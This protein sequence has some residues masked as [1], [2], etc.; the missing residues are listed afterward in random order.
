MICIHKDFALNIL[1]GFFWLI[2]IFDFLE[3]FQMPQYLLLIILILI[4]SYVIIFRTQLFVNLIIYLIIL[5]PIFGAFKLFETNILLSDI[6]LLFSTLILLLRKKYVKNHYFF[7]LIYFLLFLHVLIHLALEDLINIKPLV[8]IIE[9]FA[10]YFA[11][12]ETLKGEKNSSIFFSVIVATALGIILMIFAFFKGISLVNFEG[13]SQALIRDSNGIDLSKFRMTFFYTNFPFIISSLV[14]ILI[15]FL[16]KQK[17]IFSKLFNV[18]LIILVC[19]SLIASGNKTAMISTGIIF[20]VSNFIFSGIGFYRWINV[21]YLIIL[22]PVLNILVYSFFL[23]D[24][25]AE[26]FTTRMKSSDS[27]EDRIG[28]YINVLHMLTDNIH[29][30]FIGYGPEFLMGAGDQT[31]ANKFKVNYFTK[32]V[33]GAV[34]SGIVTFIIEF[35]IIYFTLFAY[36]IFK[37]INTLFY[38]LNSRSILYIQLFFVFII[39]S[40]TQIV[41]LSKIFWFFVIIYA[42]SKYYLPITNQLSNNSNL[43]DPGNMVN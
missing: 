21:V 4:H 39:S 19:L 31:I 26:L 23:N 38:T 33:Q 29:R 16:G 32:D 9:I 34:D 2:S 7:Y 24:F 1:V 10:V 3:L 14:F 22:L 8:S 25:N 28:V 15:Y 41:G 35:G 36:V 13:D 27:F 40:T 17:F 11:S 42:L 20:F 18:L 30:V 6:F 37:R 5:S 12:K 43:S